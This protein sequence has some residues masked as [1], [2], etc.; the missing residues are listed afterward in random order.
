MK[1]SKIISLFI[2]LSIISSLSAKPK[3]KKQKESFQD[4]SILEVTLDEKEKETEKL[5]EEVKTEPDMTLFANWKKVPNRKVDKTFGKIR[6]RVLPKRGSFNI[7]IVNGEG[8]TNCVTSNMNEYTTTYFSLKAGKK[9]YKLTAGADIKTKARALDNKVQIIYS[10]DEVAD[11]L[12]E[13]TPLESSEGQGFDILKISASVRN[14]SKKAADFALKN[15]MDTVLGEADL[16]HF[17]TAEDVPVRNEVILR[18]MSQSKFFTSKNPAA[19]CQFMLYG[20]DISQT[21]VVALAN[22]ATADSSSWDPEMSSFRTFD[23]VTAYNNSAVEILWPEEKLAKDKSFSKLYYLAFASDGERPAGD[24]FIAALD[25]KLN[26]S[27]E[28]K[29]K[30]ENVK[31]SKGKKDS[32]AKKIPEAKKESTDADDEAEDIED[33][34]VEEVEEPVKET[35]KP[36]KP[37]KKNPPEPKTVEKTEPEED[38]EDDLDEFTIPKELLTPEYI[39]SLLDRIELLKVGD[40][41]LNRDELKMLND[42]LD[43]ILSI[44]RR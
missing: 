44:M 13:F 36:S 7:G 40:P 16:Y 39:Q 30:T 29:D 41:A 4:D 19:W 26:A 1:K 42:E 34:E 21:D 10:V 14:T 3:E 32:G 20:A 12:V 15:V 38:P 37:A 24:T 28:V 2:F 18:T 27:E 8:K 11:V 31:V 33:S 5:E 6:L 17:Y 35:T 22:F 25:E 43:F 23:T 9:I